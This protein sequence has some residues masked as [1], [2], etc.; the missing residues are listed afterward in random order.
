[1]VI[2]CRYVI[3]GVEQEE[4]RDGEMNGENDS[5]GCITFDEYLLK[6]IDNGVIFI[7]I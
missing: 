3:V 5:G 7:R 2:L 6:S 1:M 4:I